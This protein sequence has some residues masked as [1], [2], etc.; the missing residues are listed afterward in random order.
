MTGPSSNAIENKQ[1]DKA[2]IRLLMGFA[3]LILILIFLWFVR[4][5]KPDPFVQETISLQGQLAQGARLFRINCAG[6]H[7]IDARGLL[8]PDLH[9]VDSR[10][11]DHQLIHQI[12]DG[13]TPPMPSFKMEAQNMADILK[14]LHSRN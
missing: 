9:L 10:L 14:Y 4:V 13:R 6:C 12:I 11:N 7:G 2:K 5:L 3:L 8:G 1:T